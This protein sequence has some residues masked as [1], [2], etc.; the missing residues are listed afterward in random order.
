MDTRSIDILTGKI[1]IRI[2]KFLKSVKLNLSQMN[3]AFVVPSR[4]FQLIQDR[5]AYL[6]TL[7]NEETPDIEMC[8]ALMVI[9]IKWSLA[10]GLDELGVQLIVFIVTIT[11]TYMNI[12]NTR[13]SIVNTEFTFKQECVRSKAY[14]LL[15]NRN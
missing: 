14:L 15:H 3:F 4:P 6:C 9:L 12:H 11:R 10:I 7:A 5:V 8:L 13:N 2:A 1:D